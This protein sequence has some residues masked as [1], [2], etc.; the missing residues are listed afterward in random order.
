MYKFIFFLLPKE[1]QVIEKDGDKIKVIK[2]K[3][4]KKS[5]GHFE[6]TPTTF[7]FRSGL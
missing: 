4:V 3:G 5:A 1:A 2:K 7:L 6:L